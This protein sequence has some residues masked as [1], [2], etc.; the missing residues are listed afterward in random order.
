MKLQKTI[1]LI[2][3][4]LTLFAS[5]FFIINRRN[6]MNSKISVLKF[7][8]LIEDERLDGLSLTVYYLCPSVLTYYPLTIERLANGSFEYHVIINDKSLKE[9][10]DLLKRLS[11]AKLIPVEKESGI[12]D[13]RLYYVFKDESGNEIFSVAMRGKN[14]SMFV[15]GNE[16]EGDKILCEVIFP[17]LPENAIQKLQSMYE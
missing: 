5:I 16:V 4:M 8:Q 7:L 10:I 1:I 15:N 13:A 6:N 17:F 11:D 3:T 12:I 9:H 2:F 14:E